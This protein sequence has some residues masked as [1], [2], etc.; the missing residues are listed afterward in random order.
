ML[1]IALEYTLL[2]DVLSHFLLELHLQIPK[3]FRIHLPKDAVIL[4]RSIENDVSIT[5]SANL[6]AFPAKNP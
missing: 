3:R 4:M 5:V 2:V 6:V 1:L